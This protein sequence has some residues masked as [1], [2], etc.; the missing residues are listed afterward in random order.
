MN[1]I[2]GAADGM[3]MQSEQASRATA[4]QARSD[5]RRW[6]LPPQNTAKQIKLITRANVEHSSAASALLASVGEIRQITDRNAAG[7]KQ[8]RGGTDDL[9]RRAQALATLVDQPRDRPVSGQW[10][11]SAIEQVIVRAELDPRACP[12][13]ASHSASSP[14]TIVSS[15][16]RGTRWMAA[17]TGIDA[18]ACPRPAA[19]RR[20][21]P[22]SAL[23]GLSIMGD[24][25]SRGT[26]E[27]LAPA[28]HHYL[29][30]CAPIAPAAAGRPDAAARHDRTASRG[31]ADRRHRRDRR[32]RDRSRRAR[33]AAWPRRLGTC[34]LESRRPACSATADVQVRQMAVSTL[35]QHG[36]AIVGR[37]RAHAPRAASRPLDAEQRAGSAGDQRHRRHRAA[38]RIPRRRGRQPSH[39]GGVDP[40]Q[41]RDRRAI[42][43]L[44][45]RLHDADVNV[46]FHVIEALGRLRATEA[47]EALTAIAL[48]RDF[49][50]AFPAIQALSQ[51][52]SSLGRAAPGPAAR[53]RIAA[54]AGHRS[55]R[56]AG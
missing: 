5:A 53:G 26:V 49:F 48:E 50:L 2:S 30:A 46:R 20:C 24:V 41:R 9:L 37:T 47:C 39:P 54:R 36:Q 29:F 44:V 28:L 31:G 38:H 34:I 52:G 14:P 23:R 17:A 25:L 10:A 18:G 33:A 27:V 56:R 45:A 32:G 11:G 21:F 7:V 42:A 13:N 12:P 43:P 35:A 19:V 40:G 51:I 16:A 1:E 3:R 55:P 6:P 15:S 4:D 8:T 22:T